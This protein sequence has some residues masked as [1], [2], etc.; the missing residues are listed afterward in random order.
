MPKTLGIDYGSKR[1][2]IAISDSSGMIASGLC[3][4]DNKEIFTFLANLTKTEEISCIVVGKAI[5]L[6]GKETDSSEF[7]RLFVNKLEKT[8]PKIIIDTIDERFTS[9]IALRSIIDAGVKKKK[10][11]DKLIINE[12][13]A[14]IILQDYLSYK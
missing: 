2:G 11:K 13:S 14:T 8:Y 6:D 7:I 4:I 3:T 5:N 10:R 12:V 1:I 9:K